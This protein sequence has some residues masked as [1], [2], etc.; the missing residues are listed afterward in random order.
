MSR[1]FS[2]RI[3]LPWYLTQ[4]TLRNWQHYEIL[5]SA[6]CS[7]CCSPWFRRNNSMLA[8]VHRYVSQLK[9]VKGSWSESN[10]ETLWLVALCLSYDRT[11]SATTG[12]FKPFHAYFMGFR[13]LMGGK[14]NLISSACLPVWTMNLDPAFP[15]NNGYSPICLVP[16]FCKIYLKLI[17]TASIFQNIFKINL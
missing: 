8:E 2:E 11:A 16:P 10:R 3:H 6:W 12:I 4:I 7:I 14:G 1:A 5:L 9:E 17:Y 13:I 15:D